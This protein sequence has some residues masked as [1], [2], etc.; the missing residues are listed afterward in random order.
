MNTRTSL[1]V[2]VLKPFVA[3][4]KVLSPRGGQRGFIYFILGL[5]TLIVAG[6]I[7]GNVVTKKNNVNKPV[8]NFV[9]V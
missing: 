2:V 6:S 5:L 8:A 3:L 9:T 4:Y 1:L 7:V